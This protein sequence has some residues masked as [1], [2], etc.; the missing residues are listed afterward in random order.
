[1]PI[2]T[3]CELYAHPNIDGSGCPCGRLVVLRPPP[4]N[5]APLPLDLWPTPLPPVLAVIRGDKPEPPERPKAQLR[6]HRTSL[7]R[8]E[9]WA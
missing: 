1:M 6:T 9:V 5:P 8:P 3:D 4:V 2:T 7:R